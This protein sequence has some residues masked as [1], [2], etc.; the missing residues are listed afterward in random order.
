MPQLN[1]S[2]PAYRKKADLR[3]EWKSFR[4]GLNLLLRPTELSREEYA[5]GDNIMLIG[6]GV[7]TGR[8]GSS[9]Y[10]TA[11]ATGSARGFLTYVNTGSLTNEILSL[12]DEGYIAKKNST[13]ST[14]VTGQSFP[15]GT[16]IRSTQLGNKSFIVSKNTPFS[17][18]D[19][20]SISV[21]ATV[22]APV[23][24]LATNL[25]G[26]SGTNVQTWK[27]TAV[28][29][30]G[31][32]TN[33]PTFI[34][35]PNLPQDLTQTQVLV[36]WSQPSAGSLSGF[37][38]YRGSLGD[39]TFIA[40]VNASVTRYYDGGA[41]ASDTIFPPLLNT[42]GGVKSNIIKKFN[43]RLI[44]V[45]K[46]DP[47]K[48]LISGRYPN[49]YKF[50]WIDGGGY[51][52]VDPDSGTDITGVEVLS[53]S[54]KIVVYKDYSHYQVTLNTVTLGNYTILDPVYEPISTAIGAS[55]P[56]T[57]QVVENDIF[58]F[59]R[60]GLYVTGYEP[61]F[62][63]IIRTNE[64]SARVRPYI[65]SLTQTDYENC[66]SAYINNKYLL[67]FPSK[68]DI[69]VY[70]RERGSFA[71]IWRLPWGV[72][73][74]TKYVDSG[75]TERWV[76]GIDTSNQMYTFEESA[77]TDSGTV[78]SKS[79]KTNK[80]VFDTW[81][82]LKL[83]KIFYGL[84]RNVSGIVTVNINIEDRDGSLSTVKTFDI[85]GESST[86]NTGWGTASWGSMLW[87]DTDG[88]LLEGTDELTRWSRLYKIGRLLEVEVTT[89]SGSDDFELLGLQITASPQ[90]DGSLPSSQR[91]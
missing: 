89:N 57:L 17:Y 39:E 44:I 4:K 43:D 29:A 16:V 71:G 80:E 13:G 75:G 14:L 35:L 28:S 67:S 37:Q 12:T 64:V 24:V 50:S 62:L 76:F 51:V 5:T 59:G 42:T 60:K 6:S 65:E 25:S 38:I 72:S 33:A 53:G 87:G 58:Y 45:D 48:L 27:V 84:F 63:T 18:Y 86:G 55:N 7:P 88:S 74:M 15:S 46:N 82:A 8:W 73:R 40:S 79:F 19:G 11:N 49:Q 2:V 83:I 61:N 77:H 85:T 34:T 23:N 56:D 41:V 78:I 32:E 52:Y 81:S 21:F 3:A 90:G 31:G 1:T 54:N 26:V 10:F 66:V 20:T 47:N 22:S 70:D 9:T 30:T 68:K 91:V 69:L 36:S